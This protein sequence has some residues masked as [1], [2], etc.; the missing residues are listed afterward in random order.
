[1]ALPS[2]LSAAT[3]DLPAAQAATGSGVISMNRQ[4]GTAIGVSVLVAILGVPAGYPAAHA[5]FQHTWWTLAAVT[6]LAAAAALGMTP[7]RPPVPERPA[8][9]AVAVTA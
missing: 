3:A 9:P 2:I 5:A 6:V 8:T 4:I 1:L 7:A